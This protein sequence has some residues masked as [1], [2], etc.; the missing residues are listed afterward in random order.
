VGRAWRRDGLAADEAAH[1][2]AQV[3]ELAQL[4]G[5]DLVAGLWQAHRDVGADPAGRAGEHDDPV[6]GVDALVDVVGDQQDGDVPLAAHPQH[7]VLQV[8]PGLRVH[9]AERLVHEQQHRIAGQRPGDGDP[10]LHAAGQL[11]RVLVRGVGEAHRGQCRQRRRVTGRAAVLRAAQ[12]QRDVVA[13]AQPRIQR[14]AVVLEDHGEPVRHPGDRRAVQHDP[15]A[16]GLEQPGDAAQQRGLAAARWPDDGDKLAVGRLQA[17]PLDGR[18][19]PVGPGQ[20]GYLEHGSAPAGGGAGDAVIRH[21]PRPSS[22]T[23]PGP[24]PSPPSD[25]GA[26]TAGSYPTG[27]PARYRPFPYLLVAVTIMNAYAPACLG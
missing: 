11:P 8:F 20:V 12:R 21:S 13:D 7:E 17:D 26:S 3:R 9:R 5:V 18:V 25:L 15:A 10:L 1:L 6:A 19:V 4:L 24:K 23:W 22:M 27:R 16:C 14:A 2:S